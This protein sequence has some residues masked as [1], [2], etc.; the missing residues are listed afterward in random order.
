MPRPLAGTQLTLVTFLP[1]TEAREPTTLPLG[2]SSPL[3]VFSEDK[4]N[5]ISVPP[6][7]G[8]RLTPTEWLI[9]RD[10]PLFSIT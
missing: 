2:H 7:P 4:L 3:D 6:P 10:F 9:K 8:P 5:N 1:S